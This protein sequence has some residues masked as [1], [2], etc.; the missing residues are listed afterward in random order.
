M[1]YMGCII[2]E[3]FMKEGLQDQIDEALQRLTNSETENGCKL[4][5][6]NFSVTEHFYPSGGSATRYSV[7]IIYSF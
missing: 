7:L 2:L 5:N 3:D 6:V 4:M 1:S